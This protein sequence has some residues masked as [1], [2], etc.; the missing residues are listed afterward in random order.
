MRRRL[1][2]KTTHGT[3]SVERHPARPDVWDGPASKVPFSAFT[4][5]EIR[6]ILRVAVADADPSTAVGVRAAL[7]ACGQRYELNAYTEAWRAMEGIACRQPQVLIIAQEIGE[8]HGIECASRLMTVF[9]ELS[10]IMLSSERDPQCI[11]RAL[12]T[13]VLAYCIKPISA[14]ELRVTMAKVVQ[15]VPFLCPQSGSLL[16]GHLR[17][18]GSVGF[19][20]LTP[21]EREIASLLPTGASDKE[22]ASSLGLAP[23]TVHVQLASL[24]RKLEVHD[25]KQATRKLLGL[26]MPA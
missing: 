20:P 6:P 8:T 15:R 13:G 9:P 3:S 7:D 26:P 18:G 19:F 12:L 5:L 1:R 23:G 17:K 16:A 14:Q 10:I 21:R 24:Y 2:P 11:L 22:I 4:D 25:R